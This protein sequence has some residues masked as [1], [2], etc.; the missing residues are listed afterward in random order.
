MG[1]GWRRCPA[2]RDWAW[3]TPSW[4]FCAIWCAASTAC[5]RYGSYQHYSIR[6]HPGSVMLAAEACR[7]GKQTYAAS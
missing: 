5:D 3:S 1:S 6:D 4:T 2:S 7:S